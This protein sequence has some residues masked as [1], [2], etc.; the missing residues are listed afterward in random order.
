MRQ[1]HKV[2]SPPQS[3]VFAFRGR[4]G[5]GSNAAA[6]PDTSIA[7]KRG[8]VSRL[9]VCT[10]TVRRGDARRGFSSMCLTLSTAD[11]SVTPV[12]SED[13]LELTSASV[14]VH[15][16]SEGPGQASVTSLIL[17][18]ASVQASSALLLLAQ[19][20]CWLLQNR[21]PC[22]DNIPLFTIRSLTTG[23][24]CAARVPIARLET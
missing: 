16:R 23:H 6:V 15:F 3:P 21:Q 10:W 24:Y 18:S 13:T 19:T 8:V 12:H 17:Y 9:Y 4:L 5:S 22:V 14:F 2:Y 1:V 11:A 20:P 7:C